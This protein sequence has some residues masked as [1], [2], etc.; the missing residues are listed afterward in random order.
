MGAGAT[1]SDRDDVGDEGREGEDDGGAA[2]QCLHGTSRDTR[3]Q[4]PQ[5]LA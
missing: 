2:E 1:R 3:N 5:G 4:G